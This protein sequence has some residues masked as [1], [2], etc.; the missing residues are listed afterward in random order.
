[1]SEKTKVLFKNINQGVVE[2]VTPFSRYRV[3]VRPGDKYASAMATNPKD[4]QALL[5]KGGFLEV[6]TEKNVGSD[7]KRGRK[8][9]KDD[10]ADSYTT[11][12]KT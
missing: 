2:G 11:D 7:K 12:S 5:S 4:I 10:G 3:F 8:K 6:K 1:M 9:V